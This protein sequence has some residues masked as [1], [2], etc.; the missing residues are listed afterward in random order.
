MRSSSEVAGG[1]FTLILIER[2][3][4]SSSVALGSWMASIVSTN[5]M[6]LARV[7]SRSSPNRIFF[8]TM[9]PRIRSGPKPH[10]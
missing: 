5:T 8:F 7:V 1:Y 10:S 6:V 3:F 2:R 4:V 9:W